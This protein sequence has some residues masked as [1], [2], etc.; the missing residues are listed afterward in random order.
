MPELA[1]FSG[2]MDCGKSTLA[3]QIGHN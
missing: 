2:T 1:F 3:L